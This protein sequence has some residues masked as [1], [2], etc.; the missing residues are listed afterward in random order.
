MSLSAIRNE[1]ETCF[2][3]AGRNIPMIHYDILTVKEF[4]VYQQFKVRAPVKQLH[5][6]KSTRKIYLNICIISI[7]T[8][9][10]YITI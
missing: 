3:A 2:F 1:L 5:F 9:L 6:H 8:L 4:A 10:I 7:H